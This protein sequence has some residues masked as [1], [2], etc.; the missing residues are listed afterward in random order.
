L[1]SGIRV[2]H[3]IFSKQVMF[4]NEA[5]VMQAVPLRHDSKG[6]Y[7]RIAAMVAKVPASET[8]ET[9]STE[10]AEATPMETTKAA[11]TAT[12]EGHSRRSRVGAEAEAEG[13]AYDGLIHR[14]SPRSARSWS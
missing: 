8:A 14:N 4:S 6:H 3:V 12:S 10:A 1:I 13:K 11:E 2:G 9:T 5:R 7:C